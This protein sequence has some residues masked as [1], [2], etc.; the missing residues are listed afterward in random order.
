MRDV[1][2]AAVVLICPLMMLWMMRGHGHGHG[3]GRGADE[4]E[5][6]RNGQAHAST[7]ELR[8]QRADLDR[9]IAEREQYERDDQYGQDA[10]ASRSG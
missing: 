10:T 7:D 9:Q 6:H 3:H 5:Y 1:L 8:R 4:H 2:V